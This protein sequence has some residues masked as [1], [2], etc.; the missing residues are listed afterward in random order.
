MKSF[1][2]IDR[3][4]EEE[5]HYRRKLELAPPW[6][7]LKWQVL[8]RAKPSG[9]PRF[10]KD[11]TRRDKSIRGCVTR[12]LQDKYFLPPPIFFI[13]NK[14]LLYSSTHATVFL[15]TMTSLFL[16]RFRREFRIFC[17][18]LQTS[19]QNLQN[20]RWYFDLLMTFSSPCSGLILQRREP[21]FVILKINRPVNTP[22]RRPS[23]RVARSML[24]APGMFLF[25]SATLISF[26]LTYPSSLQ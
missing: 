6:N 8:E 10:R 18:V 20:W 23:M 12:P 19:S 22:W 15:L 7:L 11:W 25:K 5:Q 2:K 14:G 13:R 9:C 1:R 21:H 16:E 3:L 26:W 24:W 4:V 17:Q